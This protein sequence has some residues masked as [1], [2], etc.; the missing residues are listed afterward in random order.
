MS[1]V[2]D[3]TMPA[4]AALERVKNVH[5]RVQGTIL[6]AEPLLGLPTL[7]STHLLLWVHAT[8]IESAWLPAIFLSSCSWRTKHHITMIRKRHSVPR[9]RS[10]I[11]GRPDKYMESMLAEKDRCGPTAALAAEFLP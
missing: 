8:L 2:F 5:R 7:S 6:P 10:D 11:V 9:R 4:R 3:D 1:I